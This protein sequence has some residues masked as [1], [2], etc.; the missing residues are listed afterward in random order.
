[1]SSSFGL[2]TAKNS[3]T[4]VFSWKA[5]NAAGANLPIGSYA[6]TIESRKTAQTFS[7]GTIDVK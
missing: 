5:V 6:V 7:G 2:P 1:M 4:W 3:W